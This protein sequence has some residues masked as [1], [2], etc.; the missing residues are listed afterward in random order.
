MILVLGDLIADLN[1]RVAGLC[2][3]PGDLQRLRRLEV[4]PGG[5]TNVAI[6]AR[7][8]DL[9][10]ACLGEI[11]DDLFGRL[12]LE[13][14]AREGIDTS[15]I[16]V[17][18]GARTPVAGVVVDERAEPAYLGFPGTLQLQALPERWRLAL[19]QAEALAADGWVEY[20]AQAAMILEAFRSARAA[21]AGVFFDP[22]PG[23]PA[24]DNGWHREAA[25]RA[26]VVV[27]T[28][29]EAA[30]LCDEA[31]PRRAARALYAAG[32]ELVIVKRGPAGC[33]LFDGE[34]TV[35]APGFPVDARD[36]TGAGDSFMGAILYGR[37]QG[38]SLAA[39]GTL[40][41]ATGAA[42]VQKFGTGHNM[43]TPAEIAAVL[44]RFGQDPAAFGL[45]P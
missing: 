17:S 25:A 1:L 11:G 34:E 27:A 35:L 38:F 13:S 20:A 31:E 36:A 10:V 16:V 26:T 18:A 42:K 39:L 19:Q 40:G 8:F 15:Q 37:Q 2:L 9:P 32:P 12:L 44:T 23:N 5:A 21:G 33:L 45:P 22:G 4:G 30:R 6:T 41:N 3:Q 14:L 43:P 28:T 7:R 24:V 29:A